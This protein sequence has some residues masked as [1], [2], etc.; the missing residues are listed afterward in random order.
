MAAG[1]GDAQATAMSAAMVRLEYFLSI[2]A[3][4]R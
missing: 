3:S 2:F 1:V 4:E